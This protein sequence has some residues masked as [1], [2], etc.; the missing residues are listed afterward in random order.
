MR[1]PAPRGPSPGYLR[2]TT[3]ASTGP[4]C[5]GHLPRVVKPFFATLRSCGGRTRLSGAVA[6]RRS[7]AVRADSPAYRRTDG[8]GARG[9][10]AR[11]L[12]TVIGSW[13]A[14]AAFWSSLRYSSSERCS[15]VRWPVARSSG[16]GAARRPTWRR[17]FAGCLMGPLRAPHAGRR[18]V[19]ANR[20]RARPIQR[21]PRSSHVSG[22]AMATPHAGRGA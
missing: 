2:Q 18:T 20:W 8:A 7:C 17:P 5:S 14:C 21:A 3:P 6:Q 11:P 1:E 9:R 13:R 22:S 12:A 16:S 10:Y 4:G 19:A 15:S